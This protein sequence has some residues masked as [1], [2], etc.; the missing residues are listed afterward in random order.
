M[1]VSKRLLKKDRKQSRIK[2][3]AILSLVLIMLSAG[4][5]IYIWVSNKGAFYISPLAK[6]GVSKM[7]ILEKNL[8]AKQVQYLSINTKPDGSLGIILKQG[9]EVIL[10]SKK[11]IGAQVSSLQLIL[12]RLTIEGKKLKVLDFRYNDPVISF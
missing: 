10:S 11:D 3:L 8:N 6:Q 9:G 1:F 4:I 2:K 7:V 5:F 12:S